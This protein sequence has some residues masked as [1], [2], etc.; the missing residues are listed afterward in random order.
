MPLLDH[1]RPPLS[2]RFHW[3]SFLSNWETR[4][5][6]ALIDILQ[7]E[8][9][10][11]EQAEYPNSY[12]VNIFATK[13]NP[14]LVA[15]IV[16]ISPANKERLDERRRFAAKYAAYLQQGVSVVMIDIVTSSKANLHNETLRLMEIDPKHEMPDDVN[17][18]AVAYRPVTRQ[19]RGE[20][21]VW[22]TAFA[23]GDPLPTLPL[24]LTG[25]LFVPVDFESAYQ[26][27][28][29]RRRIG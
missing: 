4:L 16:L 21:D 28:C 26:E 3:E 19:G 11:E 22:P 6:D 18:Y 29:R 14:T 2:R 13:D 25:D 7:R 20:I 15:T 1:F 12:K 9:M 5:A 17:L 24:R 10:A 23:L 8:Y 27:A